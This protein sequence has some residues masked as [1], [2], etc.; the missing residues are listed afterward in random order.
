MSENWERL[1]METTDVCGH[2]DIDWK[3]KP[4]LVTHCTLQA[5]YIKRGTCGC[6]ECDMTRRHCAAHHVEHLEGKLAE[7][8]RDE[9]RLVN[10]LREAL[11]KK[12]DSDEAA[13]LYAAGLKCT[14]PP[15]AHPIGTPAPSSE[16]DA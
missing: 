15:P 8:V 3:T 7:L 4:V 11:P 1:P 9:Q 12:L 5:R 14:P 2:T 16:H 6:G 10:K 13:R